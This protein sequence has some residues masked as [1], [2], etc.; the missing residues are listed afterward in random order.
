MQAAK[1]NFK[2]WFR[3]FKRLKLRQL[4]GNLPDAHGAVVMDARLLGG[5]EFGIGARGY[6]L[7]CQGGIAKTHGTHGSCGV[8]MLTRLATW[9]IGT[10]QTAC[11]F[12]FDEKLVVLC[13]F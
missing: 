1:I 8:A 2:A 12:F 5:F 6:P 10:K 9:G 13:H 3:L 11:R 4:G 7:F